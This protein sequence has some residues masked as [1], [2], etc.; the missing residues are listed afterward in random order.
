MKSILVRPASRLK[1]KVSLLGDKSIAHRYLIL[2]SICKGQTRIKN[3]PLNQD[4]LNTLGALRKLGV[5]ISLGSKRNRVAGVTIFGKGLRGLNKPARPICVGDSGTTLRLILGILAGQTFKV[6]LKAGKSLSWRPMLRVTHPLRMMG[7]KIIARQ[8]LTS[9]LQSPIVKFEEYP[10]IIIKGGN[11]NPIRYKLPVA[12]AQV[13]SAILFAGLFTNRA[14]EV[15]EP[16]KTRDHTERLLKVFGA[17]IKVLENKIVIKGGQELITPG[18]VTVPG[19]ISSAS[20]LI[21]AS[22]ILPFSC[23]RIK[24]VGL[25]HSRTGYLRVLKRMGA[26]IHIK[27]YRPSYRLWEPIGDLCVKSSNLKGIVVKKEEIPVLIDELPV[28]MVAACYAKGK[29][30]FQG[31]GELHFKE[32]DRI[33][34]MSENLQKMGAVI[35]VF[36]DSRGESIIIEGGKT[37]IG[38]KLRSFGDHRT[39]MSLMVCGLKAKGV[40]RIDDVNCI[41]KSFPGFPAILK[42]LIE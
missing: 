7:A 14:T 6:K 22:L 24:G 41:N 3:F 34:S 12:S 35:R 15:I 2:G 42:S 8:K 5:K 31:I 30:V 13:K 32:A 16:I 9:N 23:L 25:N 4:C 39:A 18:I 11:L 29:T 10:P 17:N 38:S 1:G 37:L 27:S 20:F 28:L 36:K 26:D 19:D 40:T 21:V 33:T